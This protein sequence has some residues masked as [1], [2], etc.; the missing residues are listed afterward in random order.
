MFARRL[1][2]GGGKVGGRTIPVTLRNLSLSVRSER[3]SSSATPPLPF[4][5]RPGDKTAHVK[6]IIGQG[7]VCVCVRRKAGKEKQ[8]Q[9]KGDT[10]MP[11]AAKHKSGETNNW[12]RLFRKHTRRVFSEDITLTRTALISYLARKEE[13]GATVA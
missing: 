1:N 4:C 7:K 8:S 2:A 5:E 12:R 11:P 9:R 3:V 10:T 6:E 13:K